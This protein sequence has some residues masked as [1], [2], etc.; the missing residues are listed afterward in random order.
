MLL[1]VI[2]P[3]YNSAK[4]IGRLMRDLEETLSEISHEVIMVNDGSQ[5]E[6]EKIG[7]QLTKI[8]KN[9]CWVNL[10]KNFGEFNAVMCGLRLAQGQY[11]VMI[12][13]DFQQPPAEILK[14]VKKAQQEQLDVVYGI[15]AQKQHH[16]FR[17]IGSRATNIL[18]TRL[19]SKPAN[20]YLSSFK[21]IHQE[22]VQEI[23]Q[24][25]GPYPYLDGLI[26]RVTNRVGQVVVAHE[27]RQEGRS[28]YTISKLVNLF[29]SVLF[30][31]SILP[32][33][34]IGF[35]GWIMLGFYA[36]FSIF[37][38]FST[39]PYPVSF[40]VLLILGVQL[41]SLSIVG[42][43]AARDYLGKNHIERQF[44][45]KTIIHAE[46]NARVPKDV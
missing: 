37:N 32:V 44:V 41:I 3:V 10:R 42:E 38:L 39:T 5:D 33:R 4:T 18:T 17:N 36:I 29:L 35:L 1:S 14:L 25:T 7:E 27:A 23:I 31:Y 46:H 21:L 2:I 40:F 24:Y 6:S 22:V 13:D 43:Y 45:I 16:W 30:G 15:Y 34:V 28:G 11:A 20:L 8:Y 9:L 26:F 12:D 19:L